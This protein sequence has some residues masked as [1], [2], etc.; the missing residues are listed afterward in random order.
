M[1]KISLPRFGK[2][3]NL[4]VETLE[5]LGLDVLPPPP[6]TRRTI[7][8]GTKY[9]PEQVCYPFKVTLGTMMEALD[10][11]ANALLMIDTAGWC[12]LRCYHV[13]QQQIL[14][15]LGYNFKMITINIRQPLKTL[16]GLKNMNSKTSTL[17]VIKELIRFF[18][19]VRKMD[20]LENA[21][22]KNSEIKVGI[23]GEI[24]VVNENAVNMDIVKK[25]QNL[26]AYVDKWLGLFNGLIHALQLLSHI[27]GLRKYR[28]IA[29]KY[30][31]ERVGGHAGE[32]LVRLV[33]YAE[34]DYD[35]VIILKP[36]NCNPES[37]IEHAIEKIGH[38][39]DMPIIQISIDESTSETHFLTRI[40][41]FIDMLRMRKDAGTGH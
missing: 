24:H 12:I 33:K 41:S 21:I 14:E 23:A 2:Y 17:K 11:G 32:N 20:R 40:E 28:K 10:L 3:T 37:I 22:N 30:F 38:D 18:K 8:L 7:E 25:L 31:P 4:I 36:F 1:Q 16:K 15:D 27:K 13:V 35:G 26:G 6:I 34:E 5:N 39:Y 29:W 9:S 19:K